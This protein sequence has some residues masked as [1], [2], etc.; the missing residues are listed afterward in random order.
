[1]VVKDNEKLRNP[2]MERISMN[3]KPTKE[4]KQ[5]HVSE[6][7]Q[8]TIPKRFYDSLGLGS[9]I[10]CELR[11]NE[12]VLR[13]IPQAADFSEEIL[14]DLV[15]Q[16]YEGQNLIHEFQKIKSQI[17]PA[18]EKLID[19]SAFAAENLNGNGDEQTEA[20]FGDLKE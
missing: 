15:A 14:K 10:I 12:I 18:V 5:I 4:V 3:T 8:I 13:E 6:K 19:E 11:G 16:G 1:M 9:E 7:R 17:R 20:L 2:E